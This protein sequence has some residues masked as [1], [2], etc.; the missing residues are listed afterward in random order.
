MQPDAEVMPGD[1]R[2]QARRQPAE[3]MGPFPLAAQGVREL[4]MDRLHHLADAREPAPPWLGPRP[5]AG[6]PRWADDLGAV[7][8]PPRR[9]VRLA[10]KALVDA[11]RT[12]RGSSDTGQPRLGSAAPGKKRLRQRLILG[13]GGSPTTAGEHPHWVDGQQEGAPC[14]PAQPVPPAHVGQP[15]QPPCPPALGIPGR[16]PGAVEGCIGPALG[17]SEVDEVQKKRHQGRVLPPD[18]PLVLFSGGQ[19]RK[20]GPELALG[21]AGKAP[22]TAKALP[23]P[24]QGPGHHLTP[25]QSRRWSWVWRGGQRGLVTV[26]D[27]NGK[28][29]QEGVHINHRRAPYLGEERAMLPAGGTFRIAISCQLTPNV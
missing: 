24:E 22:R 12:A 27:H 3:R 21:G 23:R 16:P 4:L 25:T 7:G 8:P 9:R 17:R 19:R 26:I 2:G 14:I 28:S 20:G 5:L 11:I 29:R 6:A 15:R 18:L 10:L 1:L 13:A